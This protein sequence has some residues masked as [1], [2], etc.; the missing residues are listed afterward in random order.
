MRRKTLFSMTSAR[1]K[2]KL[3]AMSTLVSYFKNVLGVRELI[4][5]ASPKVYESVLDN[6]FSYELLFCIPSNLTESE[7]QMLSKMQASFPIPLEKQ[8]VASGWDETFAKASEATVVISFVP[9]FSKEFANK[10]KVKE[11]ITTYGPRD[12]IRDPQ[13]KQKTWSDF[14]K[15]MQCLKS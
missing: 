15:A 5:T 11:W 2:S 9:E 7:M 8:A 10:I 13:L 3:A 1:P 14:K 6:S 12:I 4:L